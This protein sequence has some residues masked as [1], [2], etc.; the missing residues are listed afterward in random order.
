M[1]IK[2]SRQCSS[3]FANTSKFV[4]NTLLHI[5]FSTLFNFSVFGNVANHGLLCLI[6]ILLHSISTETKFQ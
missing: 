5:V 2:L 1:Y 4:K 3:T 6:I